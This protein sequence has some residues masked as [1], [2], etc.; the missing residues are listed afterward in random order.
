[1]IKQFV[2]P[3]CLIG[4]SVAQDQKPE[5]KFKGDVRFR[6]DW[7]Y[8][9]LENGNS[10]FSNKGENSERWLQSARARFGANFDQGF[11]SAGLRMVTGLGYP[12]TANQPLDNGF[13]SKTISFD[14]AFITLTQK[15]G[16]QEA[17]GQ[18]DLSLG[19]MG[20]PFLR[21]KSTPEMTWHSDIAPEGANLAV[22]Y[23]NKFAKIFVR[24]GTFWVDEI[25][26]QRKF[27]NTDELTKDVLLYSQQAAFEMN[28]NNLSIQIGGGNHYYNGL[29]DHKVLGLDSTKNYGNT[30]YLGTKQD[31]LSR[32][33]K[34]DFN[35][36]EAFID[37]GYKIA[38]IPTSIGASIVNNIDVNSDE[39]K[40]FMYGAKFGEAKKQGQM[41]LG[42]GYREVGADA[43]VGATSSSD[44]NAYSNNSRGQYASLRYMLTNN[45]SYDLIGHFANTVGIREADK[46]KEKYFNRIRMELNASF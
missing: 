6:G 31:S 30:F 22:N 34:N 45:L 26:D 44:L 14:R 28:L 2:L 27:T 29:K 18:A 17:I 36:V 12:S 13:I 4:L 20:T 16:A 41:E 11:W 40:A 43:L 23:G 3:L 5:L 9:E 8:T 25:E 1:M 32:Y 10:D 37:L 42:Y 19:K 24:G 46:G 7:T 38:G 33:Y 39:G 35:Q 15:F 21:G